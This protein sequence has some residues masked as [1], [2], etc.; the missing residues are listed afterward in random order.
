MFFK[1]PSQIPEL[2]KNAGCSIFVVPNPE[3]I[4]IAIK[5]AIPLEPNEKNVITVDKVRE[6]LDLLGTKQTSD[7]IIIIDPA[8][9]MN[10][11]A[12]NAFLKNLEEPKENYHFILITKNLY[13][14]IP[15]VRSRSQIYFQKIVNP[16]ESEVKTDPKI[17]DLAKK[18]ITAKPQ[19]LP[20]IA[21]TIAK[22]KD[23]PRQY[24]LE[25]LGTA[26]EILY[27]SYFKTGNLAL[28]QKLPYF[29]AAHKNIANNGHLKIHLIADLLA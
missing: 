14:I 5:N 21:E 6:I 20:P 18:L 16:L 7:R 8:D 2:A 23:N 29:L 17:K 9:S 25:I 10:E 3:N 11:A 12:S 15:T 26:I 13:N 1:N 28:I 27:K 4:K 22:K 19:D 24:A